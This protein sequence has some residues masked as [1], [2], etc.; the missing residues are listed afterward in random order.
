MS[1]IP[2]FIPEHEIDIIKYDMNL[3]QKYSWLYNNWLG[4]KLICYGLFIWVTKNFDIVIMPFINRLLDRMPLN[5]WY[6]FQLLKLSGTYIILNPYAADIYT[7]D[8]CDNE[9]VTLIRN[10]YNENI[11]YKSI[12]QLYILRTR[13]Y[14]ERHAHKIIAA[15]DL[16]DYLKRVDHLLQMRCVDT[17]E[18]KP[19]HSGK[20]NVPIKVLHAP[21]H[22]K[23]KGT[24]QLIEAVRKIN[25]NKNLVDLI[26]VEKT[27]NK[28]L[29]KILQTVDL[30][31]DQFFIGAYGRLAIEAMAYGKPVMCYLREDLKKLYPH[32]Q[33]CPII[34]TSVG[35]IE[36]DLRMFLNMKSEEVK[37]LG[38]KSRSFIQSYHSLEFIGNKMSKII[39][40]LH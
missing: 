28:K 17:S 31:A 12:N 37:E 40:E 21:N 29:M 33:H 25:R 10:A 13:H 22:R 23:L 7:P 8:F 6:E 19:L 9:N 27:S 11:Y 14:G 30:V 34:N 24:D 39:K 20:K 35:N 26:I 1:L 5:Q 32:W 16:V 2:I 15:L 4:H 18:I 38:I 36:K 3:Q